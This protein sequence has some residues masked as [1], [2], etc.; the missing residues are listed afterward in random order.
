LFFFYI[1]VNIIRYFSTPSSAAAPSTDD[2][3]TPIVVPETRPSKSRRKST[4]GGEKKKP[5][6]PRSSKKKVASTIV[7]PVSSGIDEVPSAPTDPPTETPPKVDT[8]PASPLQATKRRM[9]GTESEDFDEQNDEQQSQAT[10]GKSGNESDGSTG[11][12][13]RSLNTASSAPEK[14]GGRTTIK[15]P[16]LEVSLFH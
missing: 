15:P 12:A 6:T 3:P 8:I 5:A 4:T 14:K 10:N 7:P 11:A 2:K 9:S 16:Q 1:H 13:D